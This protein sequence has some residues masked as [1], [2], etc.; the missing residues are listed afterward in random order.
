[1]NIKKRFKRWSKLRF[2]IIYPI[3]IFVVLFSHSDDKSIM[4]SIG[5]IITGLLLR[6]WANSYAIKSDKLTTSGPYGYIRHPLYLG[7][8]FLFVGFVIML[9]VYYIGIPFIILTV[10]VYYRTIKKEEAIL[11]EKFK[12]AFIRYKKKIPAI[13]PTIFPYQEGEKWPFSFKCLIK[14]QEYKTFFWVI[15]F[16]I[17]FYLKEEMMIEREPIDAKTLTLFMVVFIFVIIDL[18]SEIIRRK[19]KQLEQQRILKF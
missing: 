5:F 15:I 18:I 2:A 7:T 14:S 19:K 11:E 17:I 6:L 9:K 1:M 10:V 13:F 8:M 12:D 3:G 4:Q 16:V